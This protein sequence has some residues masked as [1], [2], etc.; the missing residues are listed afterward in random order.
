MSTMQKHPTK[1]GRSGDEPRRTWVATVADLG[2]PGVVLRT[3]LIVTMEDYGEEIIVTYP[4]IHGRADVPNGT[5][6]GI[7]KQLR[8]EHDD[9]SR[10]VACP[11]SGSE[12]ELH[13]RTLQT[14]DRI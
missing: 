3:P 8:L 14:F 13:L 10:F 5:L 9:F 2:A 11:M 12:Y 4:A 6:H 7:R 1:T